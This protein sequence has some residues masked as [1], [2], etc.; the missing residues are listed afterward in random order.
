[1]N[2]SKTTRLRQTA[3]VARLSFFVA[4]LLL[5]NTTAFCQQTAEQDF[6]KL[7]WLAGKWTRTNVKPGQSGSEMWA[8]EAPNSMK[9]QGE[10]IK[11]TDTIFV[12]KLEL[13]I[14]D[15]HIF[16]VVDGLDNQ[17]PTHFKITE[18][19]DDSFVCENK[20]H[21]FPKKIAY[22]R[23]DQGMTATISGDGKS[24]DFIFIKKI[25]Q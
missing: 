25:G 10:T 5:L 6:K 4:A 24:I 2:H 14:K 12:E 7:E 22:K 11:G 19:S 1:M 21:D 3:F 13:L 23:T 18:I 15:K 8:L 16:Y 17:E 9:G 20:E